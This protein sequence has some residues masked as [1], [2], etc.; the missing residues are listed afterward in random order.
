MR[1]A[2]QKPLADLAAVLNRGALPVSLKTSRSMTSHIV[3][4]LSIERTPG[5][6]I[7]IAAIH[8]RLVSD[9][10]AFQKTDAG[11]AQSLALDAPGPR[12]GGT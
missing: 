5:S 11:T 8:A 4:A 6:R 9:V 12:R 1:T 2:H 3:V 7:L 10:S